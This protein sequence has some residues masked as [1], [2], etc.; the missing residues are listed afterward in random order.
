MTGFHPIGGMGDHRFEVCV[1]RAGSQV[2]APD[3]AESDRVE[4][5][6]WA[7]VRGLVRQGQVQEGLSLV[8][9]MW[10]LS[11]LDE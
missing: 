5:V 6:P 1:A 3:P 9:L 2:G 7:R 4:W 8:A 11:G 10:L